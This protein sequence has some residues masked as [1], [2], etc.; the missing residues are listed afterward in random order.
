MDSYSKPQT[1]RMKTRTLWILAA[2]GLIVFI[3][4]QIVPATDSETLQ[5]EQSAELITKA[6]AEES[7]AKFA[8]TTLGLSGP[9]DDALV[10]YETRADIYGYLTREDLMVDYLKK[11][12]KQFPYDIFQVRFKKPGGLLSSLTVDVHM[13][14][15]KVVGFKEIPETGFPGLGISDSSDAVS[16]NSG[17][18]GLTWEEKL[19]LAHPY[20]KSLGYGDDTQ[21]VVDETPAGL[22]LTVTGYEAGQSNAQ[23]D[24]VFYE[25]KVSGIESYFTVPQSHTDYVKGQTTIANWL[26][27]A[28]YA[29]L[30]FVLGILA[31][32][33]SALTKVH[34]SFKRGILLSSIYFVISMGSAINMLPY[35]EKEGLSGPLLIFGLLFQGGVTLVLAGSVYFSLVG[36]DGLWRKQG[37]NLWGRAK[38][39]GYGRHV[40]TS[41]A[42]GYAWALILLGVQ[43]VIFFIL[44]KTIHMWSTTDASQSPYNMVYPVLLPLLAWVAGIGEEA[45]Y[46]L[47]G[48]PML[49]KMFRSTLV[50]SVITT[51]IWAFGHTLYPIYPVISRPIELLIIGLLFSFIFLRYGFIAVLFSHVIFDSILMSLSIM[52]TGGTVNIAAGIFY[53]ALPAIVAYVIYLFNPPGKE[54]PPVPSQK[55]EEPL[56]TTPHPEGHL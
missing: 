35:F 32:V 20:L 54:R 33:Y 10:T 53:I 55:K 45:V 17:V 56:F 12:E 22:A 31:I 16:A 47:F 29:L 23:I 28:G 3:L 43:S 8:E 18:E 19:A 38:E 46:R 2:I 7:A 39:Q 4:L 37:I 6:Q 14:T 11:Y 42:D 34:T 48:I 51:L 36:G 15:G 1:R 44:E 24:I 9:F 26:T 21:L 50:A 25:G 13:T 52:F 49:K 30:T 27:Y 40:L 41:M 5:M